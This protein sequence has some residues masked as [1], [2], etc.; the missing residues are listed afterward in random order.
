MEFTKGDERILFVRINGVF[1]PI[2]CLTDNSMEESAEFMDTTTRDNKGWSTSRPLNQ[3]YSLSFSGLQVINEASIATFDKLKELKRN[4]Q[5][6]DWKMQ[7][8]NYPI[9]DYGMCYISSLSD[10]NPVGEFITFTGAMTGFDRPKMAT[11]A[12]VLANSGDTTLLTNNTNAVLTVNG[13][14]D[15]NINDFNANDF[16]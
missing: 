1:L 11:L 2:G 7:G 8:A 6:L 12:L 3:N 9:V 13:V 14:P 15:F 4:R 10:S 16:N 5:L